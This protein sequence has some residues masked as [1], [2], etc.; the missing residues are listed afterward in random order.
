M[1]RI[2]TE[3]GHE[4]MSTQQLFQMV[5]AAVERGE[6]EFQINASGQHDIGGPLWNRD[7]RELHFTV[8]NPGQ[9]VGSMCM[10]GTEVLVDGPAPADVGWLNSGGTITVRGDAGDTAGHCAAG[11]KIYIGGRAGTRSGSLMKKD[12][13]W[14]APELW[15]LQSVGSFSFEFMG[16]GKAVVCGHNSQTLPS[17][18]GQRPCV[19][20]VG[21]TV[22]FRGNCPELPDEVEACPLD[23]S[24]I[25]WLQDGLERF[26]LA[27]GKPGLKPEFVIWKHW[28]K[29]VPRVGSSPEKRMSMREFHAKEWIARGLFGD[30]LPDDGATNALVA[31]GSQKLRFA[32]HDENGGSC[33]DCRLCL[34]SCPRGAIRRREENGAQY[35]VNQDR[36]IGCG[37]CAAV[38]ASGLW[39]L[40]AGT[41]AADGALDAGAGRCA[42][43]G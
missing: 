13:Q 43:A 17:V 30:V 21:G 38:C 6:T 25:A 40:S 34:K 3:T 2:S 37:I 33:A 24:D 12:P 31:A 32:R 1:L 23:E 15:V 8:R 41:G 35:S 26:L 9:R 20:M 5:A 19:G 18:L 28:R 29:I 22:Y 27:V 14:E 42:C 7:G 10:S 11:G 4:R 39:F 16:G 36:C